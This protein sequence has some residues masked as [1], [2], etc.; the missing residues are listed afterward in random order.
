[1]LWSLVPSAI[2][3]SSVGLIWDTPARQDSS[4]FMVHWPDLRLN[5]DFIGSIQLRFFRDARFPKIRTQPVKS[6]PWK[7]FFKEVGKNDAAKPD[8]TCFNHFH[9]KYL[10]AWSGKELQC[11]SLPELQ[12]LISDQLLVLVVKWWWHKWKSHGI[13]SRQGG[14]E[15]QVGLWLFLSSELQSIYSQWVSNNV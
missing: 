10:R 9:P 5:I 12:R 14:F 7:V 2:A 15:S 3:Y 8:F 11:T 1:M 13:L 4:P 6:V